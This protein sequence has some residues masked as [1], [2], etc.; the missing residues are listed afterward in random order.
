MNVLRRWC[1]AALFGAAFVSACS[2]PTGGG[3]TPDAGQG[4]PDSGNSQVVND[5]GGNPVPDSGNFQPP[6]DAGGNGAVDSGTIGGVI[7]AGVDQFTTDIQNP[8]NASKDSDCDGLSDAEEFATVYAGGGKTRAG[9]PDSDGD[10]ILDGVELGRTSSVDPA[11]SFVG[12][13][14]PSTQTLATIA[15]GDG[16]GIP[17]GTEDAN[18]NGAVD[19]IET[20]PRSRDSD[21]DGLRDGLEDVNANGVVDLGETNPRLKDSDQDGINDGT[22]RNVTGTDPTKADM[23]GDGCLDGAEDVNQNGVVD[24][25]ETNPKVFGACGVVSPADTDGDGI[26]DVIEQSTGTNFQLADTDGDGL[27]DGVEDANKNGV[28]EAGETN[29]RQRD[30]D[31]D[32]LSDATDPDPDKFDTDGDGISDG[33]ELGNTAASSSGCPTIPVDSDPST[34]TSATNA[35]SDGDGIRDGAEDA[36]QNGRVDSGELNPS[37]SSDGVGPAGLACTTGNLRPVLFKPD[38]SVDVRLG[39]PMTYDEFST[40]TVNGTARGTMGYDSTNKVAFLL[41]ST[42]PPAADVTADELNLRAKLTTAGTITSPIT[43]LFPT[44]W[45]GYP[46]IQAFYEQ[47]GAT[48]VKTRANE[49]ANALAG[50]GAGSLVGT[51]GVSGPFRV[52]AQYVRRSAQTLIALI[53]I[54]PVSGAPTNSI[55]TVADT[56][57][58]SALAKFGDDTAVQCETFKATSGK[59]DFLFVVDD[60]GSMG[61]SQTALG[62]AANSMAAALGASTLDYR[63]ALVTSEYNQATG[64]GSGFNRGVVRGWTTDLNTFKLWLTKPSTCTTSTCATG[65]EAVTNGWVGICGSGAETILGAARKATNDL[66]AS[67]SLNRVR[68]DAE[69]V[70]VLLGDAD[71]QTA[72]YTTA[73]FQGSFGSPPTSTALEPVQNFIDFF[74]ST[75]AVGQTTKNTLNKIIPV[76]GIVCPP[77]TSCNLEWQGTPQRHAQV[78][79]ATSGI[80]GDIQTTA[81]IQ[82][83]MNAIVDNVIAASGYRMQKPPIGASVKVALD[84]AENTTITC[85]VN[86]VPRSRV[87]GFDFN[88]LTRTISFFGS[89]RPATNS[90]IAAVSY[91]YWVDVTENTNTSAPPCSTDTAFYDPNDPDFCRGRLT[92]NRTTNLCECTGCGGTPPPGKVCDSNRQVCDY[93]CTPDCGG[94]CSGYQACNQATCGCQCVASASCAP[95]YIFTN[96]GTQC[97][98][99]CNAAALSC[100]PTYQVDTNACACVCKPNCGGC[101]TGQE[102]NESTC[103]CQG[104]VN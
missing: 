79:T 58:G 2:C 89:C 40:I 88:G 57:G 60:S 71:D 102:C 55:F 103:L 63:M 61:G 67:T 49:L 52:Q 104:G 84:F 78:I 5:G 44:T 31:C 14:D 41:V 94:T 54:A 12:D 32:G 39:L 97:G 25:G 37:N 93:V 48:D 100:G 1:T 18:H 75:G 87:D 47:G 38:G 13:A 98:C 20:D 7:D 21:G 23:D 96:N 8:D 36:N 68:T 77:G 50:A 69:L 85:N 6:P 4:S 92:C 99:F 10:G 59:V 90:Q 74:K 86:D 19:G 27:L 22:E 65:C 43:Q 83:T 81:S 9:H 82:S 17:D 64:L 91:R 53:A 72:T 70:I 51:G 76:H 26:P 73:G 35:D 62:A 24:A 34:V 46:A 30:T 29:P 15:D 56:A 16:D 66:T 33:V 3:G 28:F 11:C 95:G 45:D 101:A 42:T 80:R